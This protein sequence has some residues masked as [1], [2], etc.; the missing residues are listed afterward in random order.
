M[1]TWYGDVP[2]ILSSE[3]LTELVREQDRAVFDKFSLLELFPVRTYNSEEFTHEI[4]KH[5]RKLG[6]L[7]TQPA[8][9]DRNTFKQIGQKAARVLYQ[10]ETFEVASNMVAALRLP[11]ES[12]DASMFDKAARARALE[13]INEETAERVAA[14]RRTNNY[15]AAQLF[16]SATPSITVDGVTINLDFG[17]SVTNAGVSWAT[18]ANDILA[19]WEAARYTFRRQ[20]GSEPSDLVIGS[21]LRKDYIIKNTDIRDQFL[22]SPGLSAMTVPFSMLLNL[23]N[24]TRVHEIWDTY[25]NSGGTVTNVW[26]KQF[27]LFASLGD[28]VRALEMATARTM[29]ND[30]GGGLAAD[31]EFLKNPKRVEVTVS[32][33]QLPVIRA[34]EKLMIYDIVV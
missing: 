5:I 10:A 15:V 7:R 23:P 13:Y 24:A 1:G 22:Y 12:K 16:Q 6:N 33:N 28:G 8:A 30:F 34:T 2:T 17:M 26:D 14:I 20:S 11:G 31:S 18:P 25:V 19:D 32:N 29:D 9:G 27:I 3:S 4:V 21:D